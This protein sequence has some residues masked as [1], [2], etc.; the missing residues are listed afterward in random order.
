MYHD[1]KKMPDWLEEQMKKERAEEVKKLGAHVKGQT[2]MMQARM[3]NVG[4]NL[5]VLPAWMVENMVREKAGTQKSGGYHDVKQH[6]KK[7]K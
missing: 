5:E 1:H 3:R 4:I 2:S 7:K 6:A